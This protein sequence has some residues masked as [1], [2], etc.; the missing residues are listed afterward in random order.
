[1]HR[2]LLRKLATKRGGAL[3]SSKSLML[4]LVQASQKKSLDL[5]SSSPTIGYKGS[6]NNT[7]TMQM[8]NNAPS[9][10]NPSIPAMVNPPSAPIGGK[11]SNVLDKNS[12]VGKHG[13]L[14]KQAI[15]QV[16]KR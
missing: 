10:N 1:M 11:G 13:G 6:I 15:N 14:V 12:V 4:N 9:M 16:V 5:D 2:H 3:K 8:V 7:L